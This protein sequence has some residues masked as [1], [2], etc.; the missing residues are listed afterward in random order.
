MT[1]WL[2]Q[3]D[4]KDRRAVMNL[5]HNIT[6]FSE[7]DTENTIV[8]LGSR[9]L[10]RL[11]E[12]GIPMKHIIFVQVHDPGSSSGVMLNM[13][14]DRGLLEKR[15][16][17]FVDS[18]NIRDIFELT[19]KLESGAIIYVDDFAA[20][21]HQFCQA[22]DVL[23]S[24][25]MGNFAEYFLLPCIC[26]EALYELGKRSV[27]AVSHIVHSKSTRP[28]HGNSSILEPR[29]KSRLIDICRT[30]DKRGGLGYRGLATMVVFYRNAPNTLPILFRGCI[31]QSP[32][33]G[34]LPRTTDLM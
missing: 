20:T 10:E 12:A 34:I 7:Q 29:I 2:I 23:A 5:L 22:R 19:T 33:V 25:I 32:L 8:D 17:H 30:Y 16:C 26:E 31:K 21:G 11:M 14:R 1:S 27:E 15:G 28:L 6:Y 13:L 4:D 18:K 9:L 24:F 3:F